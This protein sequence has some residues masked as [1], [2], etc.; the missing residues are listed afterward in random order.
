MSSVTSWLFIK[1][2][3]CAELA[4]DEGSKLKSATLMNADITAAM[5]HRMH[6]RTMCTAGALPE[7]RDFSAQWSRGGVRRGWGQKM[8]VH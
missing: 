7:P 5:P 4:L 6:S 1:H 3:L 2:R 8:G